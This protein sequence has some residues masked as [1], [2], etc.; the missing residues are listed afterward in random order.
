VSLGQPGDQ[1][2]LEI[3]GTGLQAAGKTGVVV[4]IGGLNAPVHYVGPQGQYIGL[5]Q[6]NVQ[7]PPAL[8]G[9]GRVTIQVTANGIA[10]N[11]VNMTIQ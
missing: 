11:P 4:T 2:Y 8:A 9:K 10:A 3:F 5:D 7:I 6:V 1:A